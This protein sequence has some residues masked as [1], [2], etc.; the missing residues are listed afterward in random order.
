M[1]NKK[2]TTTTQKM[3]TTTR[4]ASHSNDRKFEP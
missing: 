2:T 1:A 4:Y 3:I